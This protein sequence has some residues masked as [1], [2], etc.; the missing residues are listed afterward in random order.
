M[1]LSVWQIAIVVGVV[2][3]FF[4][5]KKL[6]GLGKSMGEA[7]RGFKKGLNTDEVD[8]T[9]SSK[10][11]RLDADNTEADSASAKEKETEKES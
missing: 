6:P 4:G 11:G 9:D 8:I 7:I 1:G 3:I 2:L 10:Q 5:P